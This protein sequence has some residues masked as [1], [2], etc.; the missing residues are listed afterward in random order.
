MSGARID[1]AHYLA[2]CEDSD[3]TTEAA[4]LPTSFN[5]G[6]AH[7]WDQ[8]TT[9]VGEDIT[10]SQDGLWQ[11][12]TDERIR[13]VMPLAG[14]GFWLFG[15]RGLA[16]VDKPTLIIVAAEDTLYPENALIFEH[17]GTP[18]KALI[19]FKGK[20][21]M[22]IF[23]REMVARMAN[24]AVAFFGY[25]LQGREGYALYFS[26]EFVEGHADLGWGVISE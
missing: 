10:A 14:E 6:P 9:L 1:P 7:E 16:S 19:R 8:F 11:P 13:A 4:H 3:A 15:E 23:E 26:E 25:F 12:M 22:M 18:D 17:L 24:F 2:Q 21:H 20:D 5:C